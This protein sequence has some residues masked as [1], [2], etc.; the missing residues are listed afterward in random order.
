MSFETLSYVYQLSDFDTSGSNI[1]PPDEQGARAQGNPPFDI[2]LST[3]ATPFQLQLEDGSDD[4]FDEI[5]SADQLLTEPIT[6]D[7][8]TYPVG[9][10][11]L[12]NY[13]LEDDNG[14]QLYSITI[15]SGNTANNDTTAVITNAPMVPGQQY[16][17]TS[18]GNIG[19]GEIAYSTLA[20]FV[21]GTLV[22]IPDGET[23]V[24]ALR[25]GDL[26]VCRDGR[27][28]PLR[29]VL[30]TQV[31]AKDL[32]GNPNLRPV[33]IQAGA[34]GAGLPTRDLLVSRQ[35]R[36]LV[37]SPIAKR[38][39][40]TPE[41]LIA[42]AKL[43]QLPGVRV[44]PG[45][46]PVDYFH[47]ILED[48][49]VIFA[50]GAPTESL[51]TTPKALQALSADALAELRTLFPQAIDADPARP[52]PADKQQRRFIARHRKNKKQVMQRA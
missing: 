31:R 17:F 15:G 33:R 28:V 39:F 46:D 38:M 16:T 19:N 30:R 35:H 7:G 49:E 37:T 25:E 18:E 1:T 12:V 45:Q 52:I 20:C 2:T 13:V 44:E 36:M 50:E 21:A 40:G 4:G 24:E 27:H 47:L 51:L 32:A 5:N 8:V 23:A 6:L 10:R 22:K 41:V 34:L 48:H 9:S 43:L 26:V 42:A 29:L 3:G 11:V 14:F